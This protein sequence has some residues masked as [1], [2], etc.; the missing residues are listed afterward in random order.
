MTI[1]QA[2]EHPW[3]QKFNKSILPEIRKKCKDLQYSTFKIYT[4]ID[5][6]PSK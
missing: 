5:D 3:I 2:L 4:S 6:F 1:S